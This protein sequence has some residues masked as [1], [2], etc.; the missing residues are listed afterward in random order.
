MTSISFALMRVPKLFFI[1]VLVENISAIVSISIDD[2]ATFA[3]QAQ[4]P[5]PRPKSAHKLIRR[6]ADRTEGEKERERERARDVRVLA[7]LYGSAMQCC[8]AVSNAVAR[9]N[10]SCN[11]GSSTPAVNIT[12]LLDDD[13]QIVLGPFESYDD[14]MDLMPP[15]QDRGFQFINCGLASKE[16]HPCAAKVPAEDPTSPWPF[17]RTLGANMYATLASKSPVSLKGAKVLEI[18]SGRGG[19]SVLLSDCFCPKELIGLDFSAKQVSGARHAYERDGGCPV[20]YLQ[21]D[22]MNLSFADNSF[23]VVINVEAS[24]NYPSFRKFVQEARRVLRPGGALLTTDFRTTAMAEVDQTILSQIF[25]KAVNPIDVSAEVTGPNVDENKLTRSSKC[26]DMARE[27]EQ[28]DLKVDGHHLGQECFSMGQEIVHR[29]IRLGLMMYRM[30][31]TT[32]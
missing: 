1:M 27:E 29:G 13:P 30:Y 31:I 18:S 32:K 7:A 17:N 12:G 23:D 11:A 22:A 8:N 15:H 9:S 10:A 19:G 28:C 14:I 20:K 5:S 6:E 26:I 4:V 21:G 3:M 24:H 16:I 2:K 25:N